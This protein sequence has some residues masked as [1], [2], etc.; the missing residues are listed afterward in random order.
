MQG[1]RK[2]CSWRKKGIK[3]IIQSLP[4]ID[5]DYY[6]HD[7]LVLDIPDVVMDNPCND[8]KGM[9]VNFGL[10]HEYDEVQDQ[11]DMGM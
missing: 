5:K 6:I 4:H 2:R 3:L 7:D 8:S 11:L 1:S 10:D 9:D